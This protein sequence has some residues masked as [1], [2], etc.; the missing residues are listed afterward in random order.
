MTKRLSRSLST[1]IFAL[2]LIAISVNIY[3]V[4]GLKSSLGIAPQTKRPIVESRMALY[5]FKCAPNFE[6]QLAPLP[7]GRDQLW[8]QRNELLGSG[9]NNRVWLFLIAI[10]PFEQ[11]YEILPKDNIYQSYKEFSVLF[12]FDNDILSNIEPHI[13]IITRRTVEAP[14]P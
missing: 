5:G 3:N 2:L 7:Q 1:I 13:R 12:D 11:I 10:F 14:P 4:E 6:K 9:F 8:C